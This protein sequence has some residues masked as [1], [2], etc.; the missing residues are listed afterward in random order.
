MPGRNWLKIGAEF[1][2]GWDHMPADGDDLMRMH[3]GSVNARGLEHRGEIVTRPCEA[4]GELFALTDRVYPVNV[5]DS[6]GFH[7]HTSWPVGAYHRLMEPAFWDHF[8]RFW[9]MIMGTGNATHRNVAGPVMERFPVNW[10]SEWSE[11]DRLRF[12]RRFNGGVSYCEPAFRPAQQ[13]YAKAKISS[14]YAALNYCHGLHNT[15]E[16]RLFPQ[17][18]SAAGAKKAVELLLQCYEEYL[19]L[20]D[21][22]T[23]ITETRG[24]V[25]IGEA[26][27]TEVVKS[28]TVETTAVPVEIHKEIISGLISEDLVK[29]CVAHPDL[30]TRAPRGSF[31]MLELGTE[32][33]V[34]E[35]VKQFLRQCAVE[36]EE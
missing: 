21:T 24:E 5:N 15:L 25:R 9:R 13:V 17:F 10:P 22:F 34:R 31:K 20:P 12:I 4:L 19:A 36:S 33:K 18:G 35:R 7:I 23:P 11:P 3:D 29:D 1:E 8:T 32:R 14:R 6:C 16:C 30:M 27:V 2:G 28:I 26:D